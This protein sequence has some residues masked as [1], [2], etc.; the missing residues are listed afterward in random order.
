MEKS[1]LPLPRLGQDRMLRDFWES[2]FAGMKI[3]R[4]KF[5][6]EKIEENERCRIRT[7]MTPETPSLLPAG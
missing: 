2:F 3:C 4:E 6:E 7:R 1:F 5:R